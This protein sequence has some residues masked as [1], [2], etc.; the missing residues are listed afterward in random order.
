MYGKE[1]YFPSLH[2]SADCGFSP[3]WL[4]DKRAAPIIGGSN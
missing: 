4:A 3:H 1:Q 2:W